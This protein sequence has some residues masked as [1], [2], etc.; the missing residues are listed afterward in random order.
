M[1][2]DP[3]W[4]GRV[5]FVEL[6]F[7]APLAYAFLVILWEHLLRAPKPEWQFLALQLMTSSTFLI[8]HYFQYA[9]Y[10]LW[11]V[12]AWALA[13]YVAWYALLVRP[14]RRG[15]VWSTLALLSGVLYTIMFSQF[16]MIAR[17]SIANGIHEFWLLLAGFLGFGVLILWRGRRAENRNAKAD[18]R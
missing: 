7:G 16:E 5:T 17:N 13:I 10:W 11:A 12:N 15:W 6:L 1:S 9:P 8:N 3:S 18:I 2:P 4:A 14:E